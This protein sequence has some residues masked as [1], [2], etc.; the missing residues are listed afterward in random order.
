MSFSFVDRI[1]ELEPRRRA[2][3]RFRIPESVG[4][5][6]A[7][8]L[9]EAV[10]QL[11]GWVAMAAEGFSRRP[12]AA[13]AQRIMLGQALQ[14]GTVIDLEV[15][16][17]RCDRDAMLYQGTASVEGTEVTRLHRC[18]GPMLPLADFDDPEA[19]R[20]RFDALCA[21]AVEPAVFNSREWLLALHDEDL[22]D[23][24]CTAVLRVP[25]HAAFLADHFPRKPVLPATLLFDAQ[26]RMALRLAL[27][28]MAI[29][30]TTVLLPRVL[31]EAKVRAFMPP[32]TELALGAQVLAA[33]RTGEIAVYAKCEGKQVAS[34]RV[35]IEALS[36]E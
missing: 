13:L 8:L 14:P 27:T 2:R 21:D 36:A 17:S 4:K 6:P 25:S 12:V 30:P 18:L 29:E 7:A 23:E 9:V 10:G 1:T 20:A 3:G 34:A 16:V 5:F 19:V 32:G 28:T 26:I 24:Q 22:A 35:E 31:R 33:R 11:A 15:E